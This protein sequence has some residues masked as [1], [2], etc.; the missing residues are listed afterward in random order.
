MNLLY[1]SGIHHYQ[2]S[3]HAITSIT[4]NGCSPYRYLLVTITTSYQAKENK[5]DTKQW[6]YFN[7]GREI[8]YS[9]VFKS[10]PTLPVRTYL[11]DVTGNSMTFNNM[12]CFSFQVYGIKEP[13][14]DTITATQIT[15]PASPNPSYITS[16]DLSRTNYNSYDKVILLL[17]YGVYNGVSESSMRNHCYASGLTEKGYSGTYEDSYSSSNITIAYLVSVSQISSIIN[18]V[19]CY[20][21]QVLGL[22]NFG[23]VYLRDSFNNVT[24]TSKIFLRTP[25]SYGGYIA[26]VTDGWLRYNVDN[27][28]HKFWGIARSKQIWSVEYPNANIYSAGTVST[29]NGERSPVTKVNSGDAV[30]FLVKNGLVDYSYGGNWFVTCCIALTASAS[31]LSDPTGV[32]GGPPV[33][34]TINGITYY[35]SYNATNANWGHATTINNPLGLPVLE[36]YYI[37]AVNNSPTASTIAELIDMFDIYPRGNDNTGKIPQMTS[38]TTPS[39]TVGGS[40]LLGRNGTYYDANSKYYAFDRDN[41]TYVTYGDEDVTGY[42]QYDFASSTSFNR[43][44]VT[45]C[46]ITMYTARNESFTVEVYYGGSWHS[47]GSFTITEDNGLNYVWKDYTI[48]G[49]VSGVTAIRVNSITQKNYGY[50]IAIANIQAY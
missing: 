29:N 46:K 30:I 22:S 19:S 34:Y 45:A 41:N 32:G 15:D 4:V 44:V 33:A 37:A 11:V 9:G 17:T 2:D 6:L 3:A 21:Y 18:N 5:T 27:A 35:V 8:C 25:Q 38:N 12:R 49:S 48:S 13:V 24:N 26:E 16:I 10:N 43:V 28:L 14:C 20:A 36:N 23:G 47:Y 1:S 31:A 42:I 7:H 39:G 50:N 40:Y